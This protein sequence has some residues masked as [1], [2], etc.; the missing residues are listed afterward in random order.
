MANFTGDVIV[1]TKQR[2]RVD[3]DGEDLTDALRNVRKQIINAVL[4]TETLAISRVSN[5]DLEKQRYENRVLEWPHHR[6]VLR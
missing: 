4:E 3:V 6:H 2:W 1:W 5:V